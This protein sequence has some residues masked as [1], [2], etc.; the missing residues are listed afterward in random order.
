MD[1]RGEFDDHWGEYHADHRHQ[2]DENVDRG[3]GGVFAGIAAGITDHTGLMP[4]GPRHPCRRTR[5]FRCFLVDF[6][7]FFLRLRRLGLLLPPPKLFCFP[8]LSKHNN[9]G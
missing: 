5:L 1:Y 9:I 3:A 6:C 4:Y 2:F 7:V 8:E